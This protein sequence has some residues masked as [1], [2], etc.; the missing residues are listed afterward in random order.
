MAFKYSNRIPVRHSRVSWE[1]RAGNHT[2]EHD[3]PPVREKAWDWGQDRSRSGSA[4][5]RTE[6]VCS[7][8]R[9]LESA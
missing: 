2:V 8:S 5:W 1:G 7:T 4:L 9:Q 3:T 6:R